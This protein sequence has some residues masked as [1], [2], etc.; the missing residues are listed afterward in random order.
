VSLVLLAVLVIAAILFVA[1]P[2]LRPPAAVEP[3]P[4]L[5][6]DQRER[7]ALRERRDAAYAALHEL[8]LE[9]R[10]GKLNDDDYALARQ[11]LRGEALD[12]L[13]R[14]EA[15]G[16]PGEPAAARPASPRVRSD[17]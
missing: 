14:L 8:E 7:L 10:T 5:G 3:V 9:H 11:E 2:L 12:A 17:A 16:D 13:R 4:E 1:F 15:L 6:P